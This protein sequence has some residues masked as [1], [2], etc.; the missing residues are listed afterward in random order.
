VTPFEPEVL[1]KEAAARTGL[2][3]LGGDECLEGL[4]VYCESLAADAQ[5]NE[6][7]AAAIS[8][9][10]IGSLSA[11]LRVVDWLGRHPAAADAPVAAPVVVIGLFR[12]GTTLLSQ[13]LDLDPAARSLLGWEAAD[14][15]PPPTPATHRSGER[16]E[17]AR[18]RASMLDQL[19]PAMKAIHHEEPDGPTECITLLAHAFKALLW[20]SIANVERYGEWL[21]TTDHVSAYRHHR[22][23]L[24][25]LQSG[26]VT[27]R[28]TLKSPHHALCLDALV[29]TYPDAHLVY[30]HRDPVVVVASA[31]SLMRTLTGTFSDADHRAYIARRWTQVLHECVTRVDDFRRRHPEHPITDI[32]YEQLVAD[33]VGT[34]ELLYERTGRTLDG[35]TA[36]RIRSHLARNPKGRFGAHRYR[37][38]DHLLD[39]GALRARFAEYAETYGVARE[40]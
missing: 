28:W 5:L 14:P 26:G 18:A 40:C 20:E 21:L 2:D 13:L 24:Q 19:N 36:D 33:P 23:C 8:E 30:L 17:A 31:C 22:R 11:R 38:E 7:G 34:V 6:I 15:V 1:R 4:A 25:V 16:V 35:S 32:H 39:E 3:D 37:L 10:I 9:N 27:G 12:A 29:D